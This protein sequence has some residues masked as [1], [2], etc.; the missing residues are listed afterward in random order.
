M[1]REAI[2]DHARKRLVKA[3]PG[4]QDVTFY[5]PTVGGL[6]I[7]FTL[8]DVRHATRLQRHAGIWHVR[9]WIVNSRGQHLN[10]KAPSGPRFDAVLV[11][12]LGRDQVMPSVS[13]KE[14]RCPED[15]RRLFGKLILQNPLP[16]DLAKSMLEVSCPQ[17]KRAT[18]HITMHYYDFTGAYVKTEVLGD[19]VK[20]EPVPWFQRPDHQPATEEV[21]R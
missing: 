11:T 12:L 20:R 3:L 10:G 21:N 13:V 4:I 5:S 6:S 15:T 2:H 7:A 8:G 19:W 14:L 17:C 18:G 16:D 1:D 9:E